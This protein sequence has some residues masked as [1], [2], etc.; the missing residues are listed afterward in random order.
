PGIAVAFD[1]H[2]SCCMSFENFRWHDRTAVIVMD[3]APRTVVN[4]V[5][6]NNV[7]VI[8]QTNIYQ[9][10]GA[11]CRYRGQRTTAIASVPATQRVRTLETRPERADWRVAKV[12]AAAM[13]PSG[14]P[15]SR[16]T[17][18]PEVR[19]QVRRQATVPSVPVR[20]GGP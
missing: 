17:P 20:A 1:I 2:T 11:D 5:T 8:K 18:R 16:W 13:P 10:L 6:V 3:R 9:G 15:A 4:N 19:D 12:R 14:G 7:T